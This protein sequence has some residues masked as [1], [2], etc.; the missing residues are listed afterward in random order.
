MTV[1][2]SLCARHRFEEDWLPKAKRKGWKMSIDWEDV[3]VRIKG[4]K[5]ELQKILEDV[6]DVDGTDMENLLSESEEKDD[7]SQKERERKWVKR[8]TR[9]D[10]GPRS[11]CI[12]WV[13]MMKEVRKKGMTNV[14]GVKGQFENFE[15]TQP[16]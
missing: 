8:L 3:Q 14:V 10:R 5:G 16:G 7:E 6:G 15:K 12:F 11:R 4:M 1:Y 2:V 13:E 9:E